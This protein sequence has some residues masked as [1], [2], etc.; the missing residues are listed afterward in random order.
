MVA[1]A[2]VWF[3]WGST[4]LAIL[5]A[6]ETM[7]GFLMAGI[8]FAVAGGVLY[9]WARWSGAAA[10]T[11]A[12]WRVAFVIGCLMLLVGNGGVVWA[13]QFVPTGLTALVIA[14]EPLWVVLLDWARPHGTRPTVAEGLGLI[15][16]FAG[17][18]M[19]VGP[20]E[21]TD[22]PRVS[23]LGAAV[24]T[25]ATVSWAAGSIYSR[26]AP[27][28]TSPILRAAMNLTGGGVGLLIVA[29]VAGDWAR[30]DVGSISLRSALAV[31]Y[32]IVFGSIVAFTAYL[33]T[34]RATT[35]AVASTY[36]Y[37]NPVVAVI[38]GWALAGEAVTARVIVAASVIVGSVVIIT[39]ARSRAVRSVTSAVRRAVDW[40]GG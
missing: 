3:I 26:A 17:A 4:Y 7:P 38:L 35:L 8:R 39:A 28:P 27:L 12:Q 2:A 24:L 14:T 18:A 32:L 40:F 6:I 19:L 23:P 21:G 34:L 36:A 33:W 31:L 29:T 13:E 25:M 15:L 11:L 30:L 9:V 1:L 16:G 37:V 10:P 20:G 22:A 5:W